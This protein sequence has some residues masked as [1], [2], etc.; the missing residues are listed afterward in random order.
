[1]EEESGVKARREAHPKNCTCKVCKQRTSGD[2]AM[3]FAGEVFGG[4]ALEGMLGMLGGM[5]GSD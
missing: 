5:L 2:D 4:I 3:D 1:M